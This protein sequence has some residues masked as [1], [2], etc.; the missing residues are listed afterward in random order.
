M[1]PLDYA[2]IYQFK[3]FTR[4]MKKILDEHDGVIVRA[5]PIRN[6]N[7][8]SNSYSQPGT[9]ITIH[10]ADVPQ[11]LRGAVFFMSCFF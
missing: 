11:T 5:S 10:I 7:A 3:N 6:S 1:L 8:A 9:Y 2:R 4:S